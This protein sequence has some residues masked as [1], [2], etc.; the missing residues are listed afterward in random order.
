[1]STSEEDSANSIENR[2]TST[3]GFNLDNYK[4]ST[5]L[6]LIGGGFYVAPVI[7]GDSEKYR[8]GYGFHNTYLFVF[9]QGGIV[10]A[11]TFLYL[12]Y[13]TIRKLNRV[14]KVGVS[15][16]SAFAIAALSYILA[17]LPVYLAGQIFWMGHDSGHFN[18]FL[19]I[20][21]LLALRPTKVALIPRNAP[22]YS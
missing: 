14:R 21:M 8:V 15:T 2:L 18:A 19:I 9:E 7:V 20:V 3:S 13:T 6:P 17:S 16:D 12:L 10:A 5:L 1:M 22:A 4:W 11:V